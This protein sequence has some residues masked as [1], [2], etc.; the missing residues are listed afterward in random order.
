MKRRGECILAINSCFSVAV[1]LCMNYKCFM[2]GFKKIKKDAEN[3]I[4]Q[5]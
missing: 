4:N 1:Q 3:A 2:K 5:C